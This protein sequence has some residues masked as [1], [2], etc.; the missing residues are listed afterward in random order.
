MKDICSLGTFLAQWIEIVRAFLAQWAPVIGIG[1]AVIA[2]KTYRS[3]NSIRKFE[4]IEKI[5]DIF[6]K[7]GRYE[8]YKKFITESKLI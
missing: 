7:G 1:V 6:M 3:N 2:L 5:F 8:F 4:L